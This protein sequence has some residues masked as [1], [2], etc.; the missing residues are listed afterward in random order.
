MIEKMGH[1]QLLQET[2]QAAFV[3]VREYFHSNYGYYH[4]IF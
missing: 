3:Q 4:A 1:V 2:R